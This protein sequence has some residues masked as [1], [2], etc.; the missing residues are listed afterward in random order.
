MLTF[1]SSWHSLPLKMSTWMWAGMMRRPSCPCLLWIRVLRYST[2]CVWFTSQ[3]LENQRPSTMYYM[4]LLYRV[5]LRMYAWLTLTK[6]CS[7][8]RR[9]KIATCC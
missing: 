7:A 1:S 8:C 3:I 9:S 4:M 5:L 6:S 2:V